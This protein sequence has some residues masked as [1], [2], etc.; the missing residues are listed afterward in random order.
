[1]L[2]HFNDFPACPTVPTTFLKKIGVSRKGYRA[3]RTGTTRRRGTSWLIAW[4]TWDSADIH[5]NILI[6]LM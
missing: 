1:M 3:L 4:D 2:S 6:L 5:A